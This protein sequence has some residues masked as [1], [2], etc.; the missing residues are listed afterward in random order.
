MPKLLPC[1]RPRVDYDLSD[2]GA[3]HGVHRKWL[4]VLHQTISP[5][6]KG[7]KDGVSVGKFL[8]DEGYGIH[9]INDAEGYSG[10]V[11]PDLENAIYWQVVGANSESI[12]IEQVSYKTGD[13]KYW[14]KRAR[15]LHK[16][17]RW[18]AYL[19][20]RHNIPLVYDPSAIH[21]VCGHADVTRAKHIAGGHTDCEYPNYPI[22]FVVNQAKI[23]RKVGW[24]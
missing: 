3:P 6:A 19:S 11:R 12:G 9:V 1:R 20:K 24:A 2:F 16:T 17:A 15:Q 13:P 10:A 22:K 14:W 5:D 7:L 21:G 8:H 23:Y 4:I 18:V